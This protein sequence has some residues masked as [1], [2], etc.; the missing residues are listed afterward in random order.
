MTYIDADYEKDRLTHLDYLEDVYGERALSFATSESLATLSDLQSDPDYQKI[1]DAIYPIL[2]SR[3]KMPIIQMFNQEI[4]NF[5]QDE[6]HI[7]GIF[8]KASLTSFNSGLP[9]WNL[10]LDL[11]ELARSEQQDWVWKGVRFLR[12]NPTC[13]LFLSDRKSVV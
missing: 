13:I 4:Y 8:R 10:I 6:I 5:W 1:S 7:K 12:N 3:N 9:D 11:D 2:T